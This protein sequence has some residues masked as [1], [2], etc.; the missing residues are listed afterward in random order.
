MTVIVSI[1][2]VKIEADSRTF[3]QAF[4]FAR[5]GYVSIVIEGEHSNLDR[6]NLP[7]ELRTIEVKESLSRRII[8]RLRGRDSATSG[9]QGVAKATLPAPD[10]VRAAEK[11]LCGRL[12]AFLSRLKDT[13]KFLRFLR[14]YFYH[15]LVLPLKHIPRADLYYLHSPAR[16]PAVYLLSKRYG[17]PFIYD[18]HDFYTRMVELNERASFESRLHYRFRRKVESLC[19]RRAAAVVTV[20]EGIAALQREAYGCESVVMRNVQDARLDQQ[21]RASIRKALGLRPED[22][23]LVTVG[24]AKPGQALS[25][26]FAAM[27]LLPER[28]HLAFLGKNYE[29]YLEEI[30]RTGLESRVH[31]V[32][33]VLPYEVV[34][35]IRDADA[36]L[37]LYY[38][39]SVNY[40]SCLPNGFFQTIAAE[41]PLLY[42]ELAEIKKIAARYEIGLPIDPQSPASIAD[43][44]TR[45]MENGFDMTRY[46]QNLFTAS[47]ELSWEKEEAILLDLI[48]RTLTDKAG[49]ENN[50]YVEQ[51]S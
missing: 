38:P 26:A 36:G 43:A 4:S 32:P 45:L 42:P 19:V 9:G 8:K 29:P 21:P 6:K 31:F 28:V 18:A 24:Q 13:L 2:P 7:F 17:V 10:E 46:K 15:D 37:I 25:E 22:F 34:P 14:G 35:F 48:S 49:P 12:T 44:V 11:V 33:P 5:F 39:F 51:H 16:F 40:V 20:S 41:L 1:T 50:L 27:R 3:K 47:R 23:L 30:R